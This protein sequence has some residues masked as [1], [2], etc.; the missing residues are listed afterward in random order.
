MEWTLAVPR[1]VT[2]RLVGR[3]ADATPVEKS[4][5]LDESAEAERLTSSSRSQGVAAGCGGTATAAGVAD[6]DLEVLA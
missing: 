5:I 2:E 1:Q 4:A 6:P 3:Y